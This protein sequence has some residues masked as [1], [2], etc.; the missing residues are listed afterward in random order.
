MVFYR[1]RSRGFGGDFPVSSDGSAEALTPLNLS[2]NQEPPREILRGGARA[3]R[4][5]SLPVAVRRN[6]EH[7]QT[8]GIKTYGS[9]RTLERC[10]Y[11]RRAENPG[12]ISRCVLWSRRA[13]PAAA[14][15]RGGRRGPLRSRKSIKLAHW[16]P[17]G[18]V[19]THCTYCVYMQFVFVFVIS[20]GLRSLGNLNA[21]I[22]LSSQ[23][24]SIMSPAP[25]A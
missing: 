16:I 21:G 7:T 2:P 11:N 18:L 15:R 24:C 8:S 20:L 23:P 1:D 17:T 22:G 5:E 9:I 10:I 4:W 6:R 13:P 14:A 12:S 3:A 19:Y 25:Q